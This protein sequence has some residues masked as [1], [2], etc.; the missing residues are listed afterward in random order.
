LRGA[1]LAARLHASRDIG[2]AKVQ[3]G[4]ERDICRALSEALEWTWRGHAIIAPGWRLTWPGLRQ[5]YCGERIAAG[6]ISALETLARGS[7]WRLEGGAGNLL[8]LVAASAGTSDEP[9]TS[10][11]NRRNP[12]YL[13]KDGCVVNEDHNRCDYPGPVRMNAALSV[14]RGG[15]SRSR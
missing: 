1:V 6:D 9:E 11:F 10:I 8:R 15:I 14:L 13:L 3:S 12:D 4:P 5:V 2:C 7:D